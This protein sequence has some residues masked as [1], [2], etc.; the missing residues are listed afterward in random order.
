MAE[1][2]FKSPGF[3][4]REIEVIKRP[5]VVSDETPVAIIGTSERGP[6][7]VPITVSTRDD[8]EQ[9]FGVTNKKMPAT[10]A[11]YEFFENQ[12]SAIQFCKTLGSGLKD[13]ENAGFIV[14]PVEAGSTILGNYTILAAS[15]TS[16]TQTG[17][18]INGYDLTAGGDLSD[19][20]TNKVVVG[21]IIAGKD[22]LTKIGD[23]TAT[24]IGD[25]SAVTFNAT[26]S[27]SI[28][29]AASL[30][31]FKIA[32]KHDSDAN[33]NK[34]P[35]KVSLDPS[36]ENYISKVLNTNPLLLD[37]E[38][39][40]L[41]KHYPQ[42]TSIVKFEKVT[43][44]S[45]VDLSNSKKLGDHSNRFTT[46][47]SP[48]FI[49]QPFSGK[50][51]DLFKFESLD[52]GEYAAGKYKISITNLFASTDPNNKFG[53]FTVV[54]RDLKDTDK[55]QIVYETFSN[56][57]LDPNSDNFIAKVIGDKKT[58]FHFDAES[59]DE[60]RIITEG[61][62][63]N[64][65]RFVRVVIGDDVLEGE[66]PQESLPV[67]F[68]GIDSLSLL[69]AN[70]T[71][72]SEFKMPP[73]PMRVKI[74]S[75]DRGT[76]A[77][78]TK[79]ERESLNRSLHWGMMTTR[80][81]DASEP[82]KSSLYNELISNILKYDGK[83]KD[84][85]LDTQSAKDSN[86]NNKF[87]LSKVKI[88]TVATV[89]DLPDS[90]TDVGNFA[91]YD[92]GDNDTSDLSMTQV[93]SESPVKFNR[94]SSLCKFT[95]PMQGGW[96]GLNPFDKDIKYMTDRSV[97]DTEAD[98]KAREF[99]SQLAYTLLAD[100]I[101]GN[102][103]NCVAS[104]KNAIRLM[105]DPLVT[106]NNVLVIPGIRSHIITDYAKVKVEEYSRS[107]YLMDIPLYDKLN[108]R[109]YVDAEGKASGK[110]DVINTA[111]KFDARSINSSYTAAYFPDVM[112]EDGGDDSEARLTNHRIVRMPASV[113]ALSAIATTDLGRTPW[114]A[115]A[116]FT[117]GAL[118]RVRGLDVRLNTKNR[119]D[120]YEA[121]INP[122]ANF[123]NNQFVIFG[124]KTTQI[125]RTSLD[126]VNVRRLVLEVKRRIER[127]A[128]GLM[129]AQNNAATRN[130]FISSSSRELADIQTRSG[131]EGFK[132]IMDSTNNTAEDVDNNRLNG[133]I[134]I[135]PTRAV[136]FIQIDFVITNSGVEYP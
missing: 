9:V 113:A 28:A 42:E 99:D 77:R 26:S 8:F 55:D 7:F 135:V 22:Y 54:V 65:S 18:T 136:E 33:K 52:D 70:T 97:E 122:I 111:D 78:N 47:A 10:Q 11:A 56:C 21:G 109:I 69:P 107:I 30:S 41:Y 48:M 13:E 108:A 4:E 2:V 86:N 19:A 49:S 82:N 84:L 50:E 45:G 36:K 35:W 76:T 89:P 44:L 83:D 105:T 119:D 74:T 98:G 61:S 92:R 72:A 6:A 124:Q 116:G 71:S 67:G 95:A 53:N 132:V 27:D 100:E 129:F 5:T 131:I 85:R 31:D 91:Y 15:I 125:A 121:R 60:R 115:P 64:V 1:Q 66:V 120:L 58:Y 87:S 102:D 123:P 43:L 24:T 3:F 37:E 59:E 90:V 118:S 80:V 106:N 57:N 14:T 81:V 32:F 12:G 17:S 103:N 96:D 79:A 112:I 20:T 130:N 63:D 34:G 73:L 46:P 93:L 51:Y 134:I 38:G 117:R 29:I 62:Y 128:Q 16:S 88:G 126:R 127:I 110:T 25:L 133:K 101:K 75:G 23:I 68:R 39:Y 114:F 40:V 104:Y 94:I